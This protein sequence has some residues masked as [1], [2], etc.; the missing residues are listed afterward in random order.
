[1]RLP[2]TVHPFKGHR[3]Q[4]VGWRFKSAHWVLGWANRL[5]PARALYNTDPQVIKKMSPSTT[6]P[7]AAHQR[8]EV[9]RA[10]RKGDRP[11]ELLSAALALFVEKGFAATR[12]EDVAAQAGVS[13]GT[14]FVYFKNKEELFKAV[15]R[16]NIAIHIGQWRSDVDHDTGD[17]AAIMQQCLSQWWERIGSTPAAG[18]DKLMLT[19]ANNFPLLAHFYQQEV[20]LAGQ[21]LIEHILRRGVLRGELRPMDVGHN[22]YMV[23]AILLF[24]SLTR[25]PSGLLPYSPNAL[26]PQTYLSAYLE[27]LMNGLKAKPGAGK[28]E[29]TSV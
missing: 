21:Q 6:V 11:G 19:E 28:T 3:T 20:G 29:T 9:K 5:S 4:T 25:S 24:L 15:V 12:V 22:A 7:Q 27:T 23:M 1:M 18:L 26:D 13:K 8:T 14:L 16:T 10:R 17:T 2:L